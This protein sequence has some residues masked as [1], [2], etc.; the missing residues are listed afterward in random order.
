M[1]SRVVN[2]LISRM[3]LK[4][5]LNKLGSNKF[6]HSLQMLLKNENAWSHCE[7]IEFCKRYSFT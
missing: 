5:S 1:C 4:R 6:Q 7:Q 3:L 2:M